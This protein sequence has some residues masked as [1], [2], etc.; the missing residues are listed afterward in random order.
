MDKENFEDFMRKSIEMEIEKMKSMG[1]LEYLKEKFETHREEYKN[2]PEYEKIK[3]IHCCKINC[4]CGPQESL[5]I[6]SDDPLFQKALEVAIYC[7]KYEH[8]T[9]TSYDSISITK[10]NEEPDDF[11]SRLGVFKQLLGKEY[12]DRWKKINFKEILDKLQSS[13]NNNIK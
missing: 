9:G 5:Y 12:A 8:R 10:D 4:L 6:T 2:Y 11:H 7:K 13:E 1:E 3:S